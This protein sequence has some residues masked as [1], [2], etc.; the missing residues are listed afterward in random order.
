MHR[1]LHNLLLILVAL[2][3]AIAPLRGA[4][5]LPEATAADAPSHCTGMQHDMQQVNHH[6]DPGDKTDS[7][8]QQ[9]KPGCKGSCCDQNCSTCLH[10]TAAV[11]AS[12]VVLR[13]TPAHEHA[14]PAADRVIKRYLKPPLRPPLR[15]P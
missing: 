5:A 7:K 12:P 13:D 6:T 9:C 11:A 4:W 8:P 15:T 2:S 10:A 1:R 14:L 3:V